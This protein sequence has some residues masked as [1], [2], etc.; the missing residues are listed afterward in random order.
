MYVMTNESMQCAMVR[1]E[2][3]ASLELLN[4]EMTKYNTL[5][6]GVHTFRYVISSNTAINFIPHTV[7]I[8]LYI[9]RVYHSSSTD[10]TL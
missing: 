9:I 8:C 1:N 2:L 5:S 7:A 4:I 3:H 6:I 10:L